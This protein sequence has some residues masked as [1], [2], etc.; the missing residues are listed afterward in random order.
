MSDYGLSKE[1]LVIRL[2]FLRERLTYIESGVDNPASVAS[3][4]LWGEANLMGPLR[5]KHAA[6]EEGAP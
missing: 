2:R 4:A 5:E 1:E 3:H 6:K